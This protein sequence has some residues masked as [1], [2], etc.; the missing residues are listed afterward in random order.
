MPNG[1][2]KNWIRLCA[3]I[4]GFR[5]RYGH[6]PTNVKITPISLEDIRDNLFTPNEYAHI[7]TKVTLIGIKDED[8]KSFIAG[9]GSDRSYDYSAEGFS[10]QQPSPTAAEWLG[11]HPK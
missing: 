7:N 11:V 8:G 9:D 10:G 6:W 5:I 1:H 2:D 3:A 4:D